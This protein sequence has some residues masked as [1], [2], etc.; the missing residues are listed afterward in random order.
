MNL[1]AIKNS[2]SSRFVPFL[3]W[4]P[5]LKNKDVLRADIIAGITVA[6]VLIP[7]SMAYASLAG[8]PPYYGLY[9]A[10]LPPMVAALFGSSR[11]LATGPV[12]VVSLLTASALGPLVSQDSSS[13]VY[14][15]VLLALMV[16]IFQM[17]LGL[18]RLGIILNFLSHPVVMGFTNAVAI[19]IA[20]SQLN[21]IFGVDVD[22]ST[23]QYH[24]VF[25]WN[26]I[27]ATVK[28][29]HWP[30]FF[31][32]VL[33]F[34][35]MVFTKRKNPKLPFVLMAVVITTIVS[36]ATTF[37]EEIDKVKLAQVKDT[38][39][40]ETVNIY[41]ANQAQI[42]IL[43]EKL[44]SLKRQHATIV[45][46]FG[47]ND[48]ETVKKQG[49][50]KITQIELKN[51]SDRNKVLMKN[52]KLTELGL[53]EEENTEK[54]NFFLASQKDK[55]FDSRKWHVK[56]INETESDVELII[57][58]GG[59][60]VHD[61]PSGLPPLQL[62]GT[63]VD[64]I[65]KTII[66][67]LP[68]AIVISLIG[69]MEAISIAKAMASHTRQRLD[70]NQELVGQGMSNI[71]GSM[72]QSY[73]VSGSF[74]RSA[75][76]ISTG[77]ITGFSSVVTTIVVAITL[78]FFT[79]LLFNLP[80][81]TLAAVIMM[82][83]IGLVNIKAV[84][85]AWQANKHD[86]IVAITT[87]ILTLV[88]APHLEI[89]IMIGIA[90]SLSLFLWQTMAPRLVFLSKHEDG[91]MRDAK[92]YKLETCENITMLR[93]EGSLYFANTSYL[94]EEIQKVVSKAPDFKFLIIDGVSIN[95]VDA[96]GEEMLREIS[97]R[98]KE[99]D[100]EVLF[101]RFKKP[102]LD[103]LEKTHFVSDH[104]REHFYRKP[105]LALE[106]AWS[107]LDEN[108]KESCPLHTHIKVV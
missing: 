28:Y 49:D 47:D 106:Y 17:A 4:F 105:D 66:S 85:H 6:M 69:F 77:A 36:W 13:Y 31:M 12:A 56:K 71:V 8:L 86:G 50:L 5:E 44:V 103:M 29:I 41:T 59:K 65:F 33:A 45:K 54:P 72:F 96:T 99:I 2:V 10:F 80:Q 18:L 26:T 104:G 11:Q 58:K 38:K 79:P 34:A 43:N 37:Y 78:L 16:G 39:I 95:H 98:M 27:V 97:R 107:Q 22:K 101:T 73:A 23:D 90:L 81:A 32:A 25:V 51:L 102:I 57:V 82:A 91:T 48:P 84:Q 42:K 19:I 9:A 88:F 76:N 100:V 46:Q 63:G 60:I 83:V 70:V 67:L 14:Y 62:P 3:A 1:K 87:F 92:A 93:F 52:L 24:F 15:A 7:Q 89:G 30:T 40:V 64:S 35:I 75:V 20:T 94:E 108:H 53:I 21:K 55:E 68:M 61:V 74:S